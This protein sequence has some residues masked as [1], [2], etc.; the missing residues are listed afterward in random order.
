MP[1]YPYDQHLVP[2]APFA[3]VSIRNPVTAHAV[4]DLPAQVDSA[5]DIT[6][7]PAAIVNQLGLVVARV[8]RASGVGSGIILLPTCAVEVT[9][10][11]LTTLTIEAA[12]DPGEP[13]VLL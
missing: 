5:A 8:V 9:I 3:Q 2:A 1:R 13:N 4:V 7:L 12:S 6:V 11:G 10:P